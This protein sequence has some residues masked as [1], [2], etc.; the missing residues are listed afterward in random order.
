M[1]GL[2]VQ[3][4]QQAMEPPVGAPPQEPGAAEP[5]QGQQQPAEEEGGEALLE[6]IQQMSDMIVQLGGPEA[7]AQVLQEGLM[8]L[9]QGQGQQGGG[10]PIEAAE[11]PIPGGQGFGAVDR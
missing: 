2:P 3:E 11:Q 10:V 5:G 9:T 7:L 8:S 1:A 4:N 6:P